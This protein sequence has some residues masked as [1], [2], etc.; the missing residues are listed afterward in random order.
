MEVGHLRA[1]ERHRLRG[2]KAAVAHR[3]GG[4]HPRLVPTHTHPLAE[5]AHSTVSTLRMMRRQLFVVVIVVE[6]ARSVNNVSKLTISTVS[7]NA[8]HKGENKRLHTSTDALAS[9]LLLAFLRASSP[10][11]PSE[12]PI[13]LPPASL[14]SRGVSGALPE[15]LSPVELG[16]LAANGLGPGLLPPMVGPGAVVIRPRSSTEREPRKLLFR[17]TPTPA[18]RRGG[19]GGGAT[20]DISIKG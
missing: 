19:L 15:L 11:G 5:H 18:T 1:S 6:R 9:L 16:G 7:A 20:L 2:R 3:L 10:A 12:E 17:V 14:P 4:E 8:M 13:R